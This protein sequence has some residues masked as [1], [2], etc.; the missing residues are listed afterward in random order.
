MAVF[1]GIWKSHS[2]RY[3]GQISGMGKLCGRGGG[4]VSC[5][6]ACTTYMLAM[7]VQLKLCVC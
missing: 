7:E 6:R 5:C 1:N 3:R 4:G 2:E